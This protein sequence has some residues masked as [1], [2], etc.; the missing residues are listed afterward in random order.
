MAVMRYSPIAAKYA[1]VAVN[2]QTTVICMIE[3]E[4]A[5]DVVE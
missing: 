3:T 5:L 4:Q 2:E 1:N